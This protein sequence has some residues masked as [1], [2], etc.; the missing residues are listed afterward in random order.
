MQLS[1]YS[2]RK[3]RQ[4]AWAKT[5]LRQRLL[6]LYHLNHPTVSLRQSLKNQP[7]ALWRDRRSQ[8][9]SQRGNGLLNLYGRLLQSAHMFRR[10][11]AGAQSRPIRLP[12]VVSLLLKSSLDSH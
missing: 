6:L 12:P 4:H 9:Q 1:R 3:Q 11:E 10:T 7:L 5:L 8:Q 2:A